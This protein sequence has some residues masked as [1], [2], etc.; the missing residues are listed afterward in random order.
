MLWMRINAAAALML[1]LPLCGCVKPWGPEVDP[2]VLACQGYG[3]YPETPEFAECMKY[4]ESR[5][6]RP[7][8]PTQ[9]SA[10]PAPNM[11][12]QTTS[13]GTSCQTR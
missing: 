12:C 6:A 8:A 4:V 7:G 13:S 9:H 3:F 10:S 1:A 5:Q 11:V 2:H